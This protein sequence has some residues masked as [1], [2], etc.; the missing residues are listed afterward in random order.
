MPL[1][2]WKDKTVVQP[3]N[4]ILFSNIKERAIKSDNVTRDVNI[5]APYN[6]DTS[7]ENSCPPEIL[8]SHLGKGLKLNI[9]QTMIMASGPI[10][11]W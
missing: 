3:Y 7:L 6:E 11:S 5:W 8:H 2:R 1:A 4:K 10:P 9:Q